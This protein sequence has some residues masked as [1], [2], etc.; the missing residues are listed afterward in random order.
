[1]ASLEDIRTRIQSVK[2]TRQV[3]SAMKMVSAAKFKKAQDSVEHIR[4]YV[5]RMNH[6]INSLNS[7]LDYEHDHKWFKKGGE[8]K[9]LL[10]ALSSNRGLAGA[11]NANAIKS[12]E[13]LLETEFKADNA[14]GNVHVIAIGKQLEKALKSRNLPV[15]AN[16]N[17]LYANTNW[18]TVE[19]M[20]DDL[21]AFFLNGK[22]S[23]IHFV[24]TRFVNA[25]TQEVER[26]QLLPFKLEKSEEAN[27]Y[28]NDHIVEPS[29]DEVIKILVP[30]TIYANCYWMI[31]ESLASEHGARMTAM[32]KATDNATELIGD[33]QLAYN[34]A[35]QSAITTEILE[36]VGGAEA[37]NK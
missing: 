24:Y 14:K 12:T 25:A 11:F 37:L 36:I 22:Y 28:Y 8:G 10:V 6:I 20:A 18:E 27:E 30:K 29:R 15:V 13:R 33:L 32:H 16:Y 34:K 19:Q 35:R 7:G 3:T 9:I 17:D 5:E 31:L 23:E 1:M 26:M 4:A 21:I 2:T